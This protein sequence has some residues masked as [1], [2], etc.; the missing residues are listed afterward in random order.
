MKNKVLV[1][2]ALLTFT[3]LCACSSK[4]VNKNQSELKDEIIK[5][6]KEFAAASQKSGI[7]EAFYYYADE[8]AVIKRSNDTLIIG[9]EN[10]REF[11]HNSKYKNFDLSWTPDFV[12]VS[13]DGT[14]GYTYGKYVLKIK[15]M[16]GSLIEY[17]GVFHTVWKRQTD[18]NWKYVWD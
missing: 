2:V 10:I 14:L 16:N 7:Q 18:G 6:E 4:K 8:N 3:I 1:I 9:N 13:K 5:T 12:D 15:D 11:Y 17:T